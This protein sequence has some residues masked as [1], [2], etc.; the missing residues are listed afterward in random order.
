MRTKQLVAG[1]LGGL[2]VSPLVAMAAATARFNR[3]WEQAAC[4]EV[5]LDDLAGRWEGFWFSHANGHQGPLR[6]MVTR[7][8]HDQYEADFL[9][10]FWSLFRLRKVM[11]LQTQAGENQ[12][13]FHG[14]IGL[15]WYAPRHFEYHGHATPFRFH[16]NYRSGSDHGHFELA[17]PYATRAGLVKP[18][19]RH[20]EQHPE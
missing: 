16:C 20:P 13:E 17:R 9:A 3:K 6:C 18:E 7:L 2:L 11:L 15:G 14:A 10:Y 5:P 1:V 12:T 4:E 8:Q 19:T